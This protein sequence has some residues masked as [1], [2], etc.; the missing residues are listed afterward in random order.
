MFRRPGTGRS[1]ASADTLCQK[2]LKRGH[3]SYECKAPAQ[4]RPYKPRPSRTQQ[5]LNPNLKPKLTT[6]VPVDLVRKKG[7][8][9][10]ILKKKEEERKR[11]RS[12]S[13]SSIDSVSTISTNRSPSRSRSPPRKKHDGPRH[14]ANDDK[15]V[16]KRSRRSVSMDSR[17]SYES[18]M[19]DRNTR[20]RV[21]AFSPGERGRRRTRSRSRTRSARTQR[22]QENV[23][24]R[25]PRNMSGSLRSRSRSAR[26]HHHERPRRCISVSKSRSR[27]ADP[28][29]ISD[30][31]HPPNS[32]LRGKWG[33]SPPLKRE[34]SRSPPSFRG[35]RNRSPSPYSKRKA[36]AA[37]VARRSPSP[38]DV[39]AGSRG[40]DEPREPARNRF[41]DRPPVSN[42]RAPPP[43]MHA[44]PPVQRE[45]SL[46]P[47]SKRLALTKAMHAG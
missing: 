16:R 22:S 28:M 19:A 25:L 18:D 23:R 9:D 35:S 10:D 14:R 7:V 4:E 39:K 46:S 24:G 41:D 36:A 37:A 38:Y 20:R 43:P 1:K 17:S 47:Y 44:A 2:C 34:P 5:L 26:R 30:D 33:A 13:T 31:R 21:S 45:R 6:E 12:L 15:T 40:Y 42:G 29:D 3:Y 11:A 8:A 27:S 32:T